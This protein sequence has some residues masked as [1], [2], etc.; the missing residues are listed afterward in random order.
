[1]AKAHVAAGAIVAEA[2][3]TA[4]KITEAAKKGEPLPVKEAPKA[5][6]A[7]PVTPVAPEATVAPVAPVA[8]A[9]AAV[10]LKAV[11][12]AV[13]PETPAQTMLDSEDMDFYNMATHNYV[14]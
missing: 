8:P 5:Q 11:P 4:E 10:A 6:A 9:P 1:M 3:K 13:A 14:Y 2:K 7:A 12:L